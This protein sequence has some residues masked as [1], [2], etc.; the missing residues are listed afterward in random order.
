MIESNLDTFL[1]Q[2]NKVLERSCPKK[3]SKR[4]Y[5]YPTW[6]DDNLTQMRAKLRKVSRIGTPED[7]TIYISLIREYKKAIKKAK[8]DGWKQ[9]TSNIKYPSEVSKLIKSFNNSKNNYLGLLKN[10]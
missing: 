5:K 10:K 3:C 8:S 4:K 1:S 9:F 7:R 6:W 2:L